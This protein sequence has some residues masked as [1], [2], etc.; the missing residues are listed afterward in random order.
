MG[1]K[2][3]RKGFNL[4]AECFGAYTA[5][6]CKWSWMG[7]QS[8]ICGARVSAVLSGSVAK[9]AAAVGVWTPLT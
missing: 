2:P 4:F 1:V 8:G 5:E 3:R 7:A 9:L 6:D